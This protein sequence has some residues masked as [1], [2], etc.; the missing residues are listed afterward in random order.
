MKTPKKLPKSVK[1]SVK[2]VKSSVK[3]T[4]RSNLHGSPQ[5]GPSHINLIP[6]DVSSSEDESESQMPDKDKCCV[7]KKF[8]VR[9]ADV[10]KI[11]ITNWAECDIC[12]HWVHLAY[13][14]PVRVVRKETHFTCPCCDLQN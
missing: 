11:A 2:S 1:K 12:G 14:T 10:Y 6:S 8:Y 7:C 9:P 13:C 3:Q 5:P 4:V